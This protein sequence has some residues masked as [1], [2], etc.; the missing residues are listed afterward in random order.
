MS[1][2]RGL[3][4]LTVLL[5]VVAVV[6]SL[7]SG[8]GVAAGSEVFIWAI[9]LVFAGVGVLIAGRQP[10]NPIG[11]LFLGAAVAAGLGSLAGSYA[12]YWVDSRAGSAALGKTAAWYGELSWMPFIL[13]P[14]TFLLLL[15]PDGHLL[16]SRWRPVAWCA[17]V[18][19]AGNFVREGLL[20]GRIPDHPQISNPYAVDSP[21]LDVF[22]VIVTLALVVGIVGSA[23][24]PI[25]RFRRA[26]GELRQQMKWLAFAGAVASVTLVLAIVGYDAVGEH[27]ANVAIMVS[28]LGLPVATGVAMLR[29]RLYDIDVVINRT[30]VYG[31][32]TA[33]LATAYLA[34]VLLLQLA[35]SP[36][37]EDNGLAI[38]G[39]TL[40]AAALFRPAR[41]RIQ[42][43][44]DRR[45]YRRKY[46]AARTIAG[47][48]ATLR[49]EIE[50]DSLAGDLRA[51]V[52]DTMQPA[53]MSL[54]LRSP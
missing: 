18:G 51:V 44:V 40:A 13:V 33:T 37:T 43:L 4:G 42:S 27:A 39:S 36:V 54:W 28:V 12:D 38:A 24:S 20:P 21:L 34:M 19:I 31:V 47:F 17:G 2:A 8:L 22:A 48:G 50:L 29:H 14:L 11:W 41:A 16:S 9:A 1:L 52:V 7:T 45:F 30:L 25:L 35:L 6:V 3:A 46:D 53:H 10:R 26:R 32:L 15:F 23:L 49:D 5:L